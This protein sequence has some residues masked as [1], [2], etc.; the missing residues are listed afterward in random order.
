[1]GNS[2]LR[3]DGTYVWWDHTGNTETYC[4]RCHAHTG[5]EQDLSPCCWVPVERLYSDAPDDDV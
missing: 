5:Q 1:M 4:P 3:G 2:V